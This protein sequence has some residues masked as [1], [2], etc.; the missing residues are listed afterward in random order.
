LTFVN[1][2]KGL[3]LDGHEISIANFVL[4]TLGQALRQGGVDV[5]SGRGFATVRGIDFDRY[6]CEDQILIFLGISSY[7]GEK[8]AKQDDQGNMLMHIRDAKGS[9]ILQGER[10]TRFSNRASVRIMWYA[11]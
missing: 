3:G 10:P 2:I 11:E 4:P 6:A 5:Y 1:P 9:A 8:R 7:F